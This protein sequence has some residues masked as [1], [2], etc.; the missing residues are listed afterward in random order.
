M[1]LTRRCLEA[2]REVGLGAVEAGAWVRAARNFLFLSAKG[3]E[4]AR[5]KSLALSESG[6][7]GLRWIFL[8]AG[9]G[10]SVE[11]LIH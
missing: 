4:G 9:S 7:A 10:L 3:R 5:R 6:F 2:A 11:G 1:L 8:M